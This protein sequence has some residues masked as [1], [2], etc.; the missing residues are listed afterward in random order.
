MI[1]PMPNLT[2][3]AFIAGVDI[4]VRELHL[5]ITLINAWLR[6]YRSKI[7]EVGRKMMKEYPPKDRCQTLYL[8]LTE[9]VT[10]TWRTIFIRAGPHP[11]P[12]A[13]IWNNRPNESTGVWNVLDLPGATSVIS[14]GMGSASR[15]P[16]CSI[17]CKF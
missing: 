16:V 9:F 17:Y 8:S 11:T 3:T 6:T 4:T 15:V 2:T 14:G 7:S 10:E 13:L 1:T 5:P 12:I